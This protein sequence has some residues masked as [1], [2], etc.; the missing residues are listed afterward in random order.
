MAECKGWWRSVL[1]TNMDR[2]FRYQCHYLLRSNL[3]RNQLGMI[4]ED[5]T[6]R[7]EVS[8]WQRHIPFHLCTYSTYYIALRLSGK[9][10]KLILSM[11]W[12]HQTPKIVV[13]TY[14]ILVSR[15]LHQMNIYLFPHR[16]TSFAHHQARHTQG[17]FHRIEHYQVQ[18]PRLAHD[19][20]IWSPEATAK[21]LLWREFSWFP[22]CSNFF[23]LKNFRR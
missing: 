21:M 6:R 22:F 9:K 15:H 7:S 20:C 14:K 19:E 16:C 11:H 5:C 13:T 4:R 18:Y 23:F 10:C 2:A 12:Y 3:R 1:H 8:N 17:D